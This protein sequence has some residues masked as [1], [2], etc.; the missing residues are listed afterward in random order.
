MPP[1]GPG[2]PGG[3]RTQI[4]PLGVLQTFVLSVRMLSNTFSN[5]RLKSLNSFVCSLFVTKFEPAMSPM[6]VFGVAA[7][8]VGTGFCDVS[9]SDS[10]VGDAN[11]SSTDLRTRLSVAAASKQRRI[12]F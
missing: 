3:P 7:I 10:L 5:S 2:G 8:S 9:P 4:F 6:T 1:L 12:H 11:S